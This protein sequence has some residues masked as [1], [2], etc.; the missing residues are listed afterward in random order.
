MPEERASTYLRELERLCLALREKEIREAAIGRRDEK[1]RE[2]EKELL[3]FRRPAKMPKTSS[4]PPARGKKTNRTTGRRRK[5]GPKRG[6]VGVSRVPSETDAAI[7]CRPNA[8]G[9]YGQVLPEIGGWLVGRSQ[10]TELPAVTPVVL[11]G[12]QYAVSRAHCGVETRGSYPA[13][14]EP[15]RTFGPG[16]EAVLSYLHERHHVGYG[17]TAGISRHGST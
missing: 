4:V 5:P 14:L 6:H 3:L 10:V 9:G 12:W 13:G 2:L 11:E 1:I 15:H 7:A 17:R 16:V 8:W